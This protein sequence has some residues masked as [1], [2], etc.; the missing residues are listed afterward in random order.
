MEEINNLVNLIYLWRAKVIMD[1]EQ[2]FCSDGDYMPGFERY[3][4]DEKSKIFRSS[5]LHSIFSRGFIYAHLSWSL[6]IQK[7]LS[8]SAS[9]Y[10]S[11]YLSTIILMRPWYG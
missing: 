4:T 8:T 5:S 9:S 1:Q 7:T 11:Y 6:F 3:Y 10:G 2:Y